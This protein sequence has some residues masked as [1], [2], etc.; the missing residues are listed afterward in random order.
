MNAGSK[1]L[2]LLVA[3]VGLVLLLVSIL[4]RME[5]SGANPVSKPSNANR[6]SK[7]APSE[8]AVRELLKQK[9]ISG[10]TEWDTAYPHGYIIFSA[11]DG[12]IIHDSQLHDPEVQMDLDGVRA[13]IDQEKRIIVISVPTVLVTSTPGGQ[14]QEYAGSL[15]RFRFE[16]HQPVASKSMP[17]M[18]IEV[19]DASKTIFLI[20]FK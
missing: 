6:P 13:A 15:E 11:A 9:S 18:F 12:R 14:P 19:I 5:K 2:I 4:S 10:K 3:L 1:K 8:E 7:Q 16:E 20:G 17:T